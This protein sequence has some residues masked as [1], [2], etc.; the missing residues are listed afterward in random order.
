MAPDAGVIL[1]GEGGK[2]FVGAGCAAMEIAGEQGQFFLRG[3][4]FR[5]G[6]IERRSGGFRLAARSARGRFRMRRFFLF[7]FGLR[8][9]VA[10]AD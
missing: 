9:E 2:F 10:G 7:L 3:G 5:G 4:V 1:V 8:G 6:S